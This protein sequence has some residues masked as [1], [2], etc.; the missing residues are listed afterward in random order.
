MIDKLLQALAILDTA[1]LEAMASKGLVRRGFKDFE[2]GGVSGI[3]GEGEGGV[4]VEVGEF[5]VTFLFARPSQSSCTC[6]AVGI[7]RHILSAIFYL[8]AN[9]EEE[10]ETVPEPGDT[11]SGPDMGKE[12]EPEAEVI[13]KGEVLKEQLLGYSIK[14]LQ[15]WGGKRSLREALHLLEE[16]L[17]IE[18]KD[19][20]GLLFRFPNHKVQVMIFAGQQLDEIAV[21]GSTG[22]EKSFVLAAVL[23]FQKQQGMEISVDTVQ[24]KPA[25]ASAKKKQGSPRSV[26]AVLE[27]V[28]ALLEEIAAVGLS[29]L[30][31]AYYQRLT[32]LAMT[33]GG[34]LL[35]RLALAL[36][37][38]AEEIQAI[39]NRDAHAGES[40]LLKRMSHTYALCTALAQNPMEAPEELVGRFRSI[41]EAVEGLELH[42]VS[43][44]RWQTQSGY[45]GITMLLWHTGSESWYTW[46]DSRPAFHNTGFEPQRAYDGDSPWQ[47]GCKFSEL[48]GTV[49]RFLKAKKNPLN[50]LSSSQETQVEM[51]DSISGLPGFGKRCFSSWTELWE[52]SRTLLPLGLSVAHPLD[53]I[54][55]LR[56]SKWGGKG[57]NQVEQEFYWQLEDE[58]GETISLIVPYDPINKN[59]IEILEHIKP[60]KKR[61]SL[62][63]GK[64]HRH[65]GRVEIYPLSLLGEGEKNKTGVI[66]LTLDS[67]GTVVPSKKS[68]PIKQKFHLSKFQRFFSL[69]DSPVEEMEL[70]TNPRIQKV[71]ADLQ[72]LAESGCSGINQLHRDVFQQESNELEKV[73]LS[74]PAEQLHL[75]AGAQTGVPAILL[76]TYYICCLHNQAL[77]K[78]KVKSKNE[79]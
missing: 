1:A 57:F 37:A 74:L 54:V 65:E 21:S 11:D 59:S 73:S 63:V 46:S 13:S 23:A 79:K 34:V 8:Q 75:M 78:K 71:Q 45:T 55:V 58:K 26:T 10:G 44:Y 14:V 24:A 50:R 60:S 62:V 17:E 40:N 38:L 77:A 76:R 12:R 48:P 52:Y 35:P 15:K 22:K 6:P 56:P 29:H 42:A 31:S 25:A 70:F 43:A 49:L 28:L 27:T 16:P 39:L 7:C 20:N 64:I 36:R 51:I 41:Y 47:T 66:N 19:K 2:K 5:R 67:P 9:V 69:P 68:M 4:E 18:G 72:A 32:T 3:V 33:A 53:D 30:S 61:L